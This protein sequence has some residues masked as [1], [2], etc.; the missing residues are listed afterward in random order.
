MSTVGIAARFCGLPIHGSLDGFLP[1]REA[2][3]TLCEEDGQTDRQAGQVRWYRAI[4]FQHVF[5]VFPRRAVMIITST[6]WQ[7]LKCYMFEDLLWESHAKNHTFPLGLCFLTVRVD[8]RFIFLRYDVWEVTGAQVPHFHPLC[9]PRRHGCT[10]SCGLW[11]GG[12]HWTNRDR[13]T[14]AATIVLSDR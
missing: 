6:R 10:Q 3:L 13:C 8:L 2:V 9:R 11:H 7:Q 12:S 5:S 4:S 14:Q 1:A